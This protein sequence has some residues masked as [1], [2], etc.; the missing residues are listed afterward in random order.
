MDIRRVNVIEVNR[1]EGYVY[2]AIYDPS[3]RHC[4]NDSLCLDEFERRIGRSLAHGEHDPGVVEYV[5]LEGV[6]RFHNRSEH[7]AYEKETNTQRCPECNAELFLGA[8]PFCKGDPKDHETARSRWAQEAAPTVVYRDKGGKNWY[9]VG[10]N[11]KPPEGFEKV[12]LRN[13][14][15]RDQF[16]KEVGEQETAKFRENVR[17]QR[18]HWYATMGLNDE[19]LKSLRDMSPQ[20]RAMYD[21]IMIDSKK[22]E[23]SFDEKARGEAGFHI[24]ANHYYGKKHHDE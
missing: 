23:K 4:C 11:A 1:G 16:E 12:E 15:E 2:L 3:E 7:G 8:W 17:I 22:R 13:T 14:R 18:A 9:P 20:G 24:E 5:D 19:G 21:Q 10:D 6:K